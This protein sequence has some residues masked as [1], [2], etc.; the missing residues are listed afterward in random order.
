MPYLKRLI[1]KIEYIMVYHISTDL[2][3]NVPGVKHDRGNWETP[4]ADKMNDACDFL[5]S[6]SH[7][8]HIELFFDSKSQKFKVIKQKCQNLTEDEI[9]KVITLLYRELS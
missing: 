1:I 3:P 9:N 6:L 4:I 8:G 5:N 2:I 7:H